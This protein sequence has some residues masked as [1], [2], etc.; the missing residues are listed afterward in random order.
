MGLIGEQRHRF[1]NDT[2]H[3]RSPVVWVVRISSLQNYRGNEATDVLKGSVASSPGFYILPTHVPDA[4]GQNHG[5]SDVHGRPLGDENGKR[6]LY[7]AHSE[8]R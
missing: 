5:S 4:V 6:R 2:R 3:S 1:R 7:S 8:P